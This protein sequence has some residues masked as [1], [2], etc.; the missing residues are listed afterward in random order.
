MHYEINVSFKGYH[1]FATHE[2]SL[3]DSSKFEL[4]KEILKKKF[5]ESE[6]YALSFTRYETKGYKGD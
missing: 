1:L 5:P 6:G 3:T 2:R 4:A